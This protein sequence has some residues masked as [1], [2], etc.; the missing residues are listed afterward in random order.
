MIY[1]QKLNDDNGYQVALFP[2]DSYIITQRD[3]ESISHDP[4]KYL[5]TDY[6]AF[7]YTSGDDKT[8]GTGYVLNFK[9]YYAPVDMVCVGMDKKN[10]SICWRSKEKVHLANNTID[11]LIML[12]YHDNRIPA[13]DYKVG[14]EVSQGDVIG[15]T[16]TYGDNGSTVANHVHMESGF[17]E[18]WSKVYA[19]PSYGHINL[20]Y[21]LHNYD[22]MFGNNSIC[23]GIAS[24]P[25]KYPF[26]NFDGG[27][28]PPTPGEVKEKKKFPWFIY[29]NKL[30]TK[31]Y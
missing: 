20:D 4:T 26:K 9:E 12:F 8:L 28:V 11:Y 10:A 27:V 5:A 13:G 22:A 19:S 30:R 21:A 23:Y 31:F 1:K 24:Y 16:G 7:H 17:G 18:N 2:L 6:Q 29:A 14:D 15:R 3:D 25:D